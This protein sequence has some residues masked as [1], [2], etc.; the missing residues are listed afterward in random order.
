[1]TVDRAPAVPEIGRLKGK[2]AIAQRQL[3]AAGMG[4]AGTR[5]SPV[6]TESK[7]P[8]ALEQ[9]AQLQRELAAAQQRNEALE[10]DRD[11]FQQQVAQLEREHSDFLT[12][13]TNALTSYGADGV[14]GASSSSS[15]APTPWPADPRQKAASVVAR[16]ERVLESS[17]AAETAHRTASMDHD[18]SMAAV[19]AELEEATSARM[20][21]Q[22]EVQTVWKQY[23]D[24]AAKLAQIQE[25]HATKEAAYA[26]EKNALRTE[27][28]ALRASLR[29]AEAGAETERLSAQSRV[30]NLESALRESE[31]CRASAAK[32]EQIAVESNEALKE[33]E[34][35]ATRTAG[36]LQVDIIAVQVRSE[37]V[38]G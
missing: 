10:T 5:D 7:S 30:E 23:D 4:S 12:A 32:A 31:A 28:E 3:D 29:A 13:L 18:V 19:R 22:R 6:G 27:V 36:R 14:E 21:L 20:G 9:F 1:M 8:K 16:V 38:P 24:Q 37:E 26:T 11:R 15:T 17:Q 2:L 25:A 35:A 34:Q 33:A